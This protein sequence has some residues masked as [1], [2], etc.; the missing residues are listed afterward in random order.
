MPSFEDMAGQRKRPLP[1]DGVAEEHQPRNRLKI[2]EEP[3]KNYATC[4]SAFENL[5]RLRKLIRPR[6]TSEEEFG[7]W[8]FLDLLMLPH[9]TYKADL[10]HVLANADLLS[11]LERKRET[12]DFGGAL[13]K[14]CKKTPGE[15]AQALVNFGEYLASFSLWFE[16]LL[17]P[18]QK[19][20][21][22]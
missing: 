8:H 7:K 9:F 17:T 14:L 12:F 21:Y 22:M 18:E 5:D 2:F 6:Y 1:K 15:Q 16:L 20:L 10:E 13:Q 3:R 4:V 11:F 19:G